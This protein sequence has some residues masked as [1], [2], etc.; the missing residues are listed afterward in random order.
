MSVTRLVSTDHKIA[1][2]GNG[3]VVSAHPLATVAGVRVLEIGGNAADAAVATAFALAVVEPSENGLG[4]RSQILIHTPEGRILGIDGTTQVPL[5][6]R[7][8]SAA[9]DDSKSSHGYSTI[10]VPGTVA[11]LTKLHK[12]HGSLPLEMLMAYAIDYADK[13]YRLL[14]YHARLHL[15]G[16]HKLSE[17]KGARTAFLKSDLSSY[18]TGE[19]LRQ[20]DLAKTLSRIARG[21]REAFYEGEIAKEIAQD[22][23]RQGGFVTAQSL[24]EYVA[25]DS[26]I[27]RG[28]YRGYDLVALDTPAAGAV[29]IEALHILENFNREEYSNVEWG[30]IMSQALGMAFPETVTLHSLE[31]SRRATSKDWAARKAARIGLSP[32]ALQPRSDSSSTLIRRQDDKGNTTHISVVDRRGMAISLTQTIGPIMGSGV[33]TEGLGFLYAVTMGGYLG[34]VKPGERVS[35]AIT[36]LMVFRNGELVLVLGASGGLRIISAVVQAVTRYVD[37]KMTIEDA[38]TAPRIHPIFDDKFNQ[39]GVSM[40]LSAD[41]GWTL[42][43]IGQARE[44]GFMIKPEKYYGI[45]GAIQY[46]SHGSFWTGVADPHGEGHAAAPVQIV[47][48]VN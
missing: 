10:G 5:A 22:M 38:I 31:D 14:P 2:S 6:Y 37:D 21:G 20:P 15:M 17:S 34:N 27:V 28:Q 39:T 18:R 1:R 48:S 11:S 35:S 3:M 33:A 25:E 29:A 4:G 12:D 43:E 9:D 13:G 24:R 46:N 19:L 42:N 26:G 23:A 40:E 36:P 47:E 41:Y 30:L 44:Y 32:G 16:N 7:P 8:G 45:V